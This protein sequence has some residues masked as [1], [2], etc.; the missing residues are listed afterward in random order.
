MQDI[1]HNTQYYLEIENSSLA[2]IEGTTATGHVH[3]RTS[4]ILKDR[5]V[6]ENIQNAAAD[7]PTIRATLTV[8]RA[9]KLTVNL[10]PHYNWVT[11]EG[12]RH[13]IGIDFYTNDNQLIT[14]GSAYSVATEYD[15]NIFYKIT[16]T[17]NG[18]RVYGET[19][20][21]GTSSVIATYDRLKASGELQVYKKID[22]RPA[23]VVL[24]YDPNH[25]KRQKI[26]YTATGGDGS[27]VW[28]TL[29]AQLISISQ[30]GLA[31]TKT[32][33]DTNFEN[34]KHGFE[35]AQVKV[36]LQRNTKI[37]KMADILF[38]PPTKLEIVRY[39]F[40]TALKDYV[41]VHV[42]L[43]AEHK[44]Q[45]EPFT[46]C[47]NLHFEYEFADEIFYVD[48]NAKL[49]AGERI[50]ESACHIV[51]LRATSLGTSH[52][53]ISYTI[54]DRL[55]HDEVSL[56]VFDKLDI[57]N[58]LSNEIVLPIGSSRNV[59]YHNGPQKVFNIDAELAENIDYN[60]TIAT[61][62]PLV[63]SEYAADKHVF[64]ILCRK[65]GSTLFT[66][67]IYNKL[68]ATNHLPYVSKF[69]TNVHCVKPRFINL[70]TT[71]K[72]RDS[73]PLK[74]KN[75]LM[76][77]KQNDN[78]LE[79]GIEVL[80]AQNRKLMNISSL[81]LS[82]KFGRSESGN[83]DE[84]TEYRQEHDDDSVAGV[85][86][87]RRDYLTLTVPEIQNSFKIKASVDKYN[88]PVL[89]AQSISSKSAEFGIH[90]QQQHKTAIENELTFLTVNSTL[91]PYD[92]LSVFLAS[93]HREHV[94]IVQGSGFYEIRISEPDIVRVT[95]DS[96]A[97]EII[98]EPLQIGQTQ[99]DLI[100]RCLETDPSHLFV[101]VVSI[102]RIEIKTPDRVERTKTVEAIVRLY[103]SL[104]T[105][106]VLD[107]QNLDIYE[108]RD[109]V[110]NPTR[111][112][113]ALADEQT[114]LNVGE[115][116]YIITGLELGETKIAFESGQG[117]KF[118]SS[119]AVPIQVSEHTH[120]HTCGHTHTPTHRKN[121]TIYFRSVHEQYDDIIRQKFDI[122]TALKQATHSFVGSSSRR[123]LAV[124]RTAS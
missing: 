121:S 120:T 107:Q 91:L 8:S 3:G 13:T 5:N 61:I 82:W 86:V 9:D 116:R 89:Y 74:V 27:F 28:S 104:D 33:T 4:V 113:I 19:L 17:K 80:D 62:T 47:D 15:E 85:I 68:V 111:L 65:I 99:V 60:H 25:P 112:N 14:L 95:Y 96:D 71:A 51:A 20:K 118:V 106:L 46:S 31:E 16:A 30:N 102:G 29:N 110:F 42:A 34:G 93:K 114:N 32:L 87:P 54:L 7:I 12:E 103:D 1:T 92:S 97:R 66:Y 100:D 84:A 6:A 38:L 78:H 101:S 79:I 115:I 70:Y 21:S 119:A 73:C 83:Y 24:P 52:F 45:L 57:L 94:R 50:H 23:R 108:L 67:D 105:L 39:N 117:D 37:S 53:K 44:G 49:P 2:S 48:S 18:T 69:V 88:E 41:F 63:N 64:N 35:F 72:L 109:T 59:I 77:V 76:H 90:D 55:L 43:Y 11:I 81:Q 98:I 122:F 36:A 56:V 22:L 10:L 26:Q 40:E 124:A 75:S 58:P 123:P